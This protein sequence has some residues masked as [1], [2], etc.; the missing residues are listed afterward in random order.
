MDSGRWKGVQS[1][2]LRAN[3]QTHVLAA[4]SRIDG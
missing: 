2:S 1:S 3:V 4:P